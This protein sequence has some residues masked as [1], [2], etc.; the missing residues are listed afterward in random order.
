[1][2]RA[3]LLDPAIGSLIVGCFAVLFASAAS[4]KLRHLE[5]FSQIF[6]DYGLPPAF[7][8]WRVAWLVPLLEIAIAAGL[9][10][11]VSRAAAAALG[12]GLLLSYAFAIALNL[13]A[14][15]DAI[16]CGCGGL[17]DRRPI[18]AWM[19]WRNLLLA[20][21][22]ALAMLPWNARALEWTDGVTLGFGLAALTLLYFCAERLL[23][24]L[25][26]APAAGNRGTP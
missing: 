8:R 5:K 23:G 11:P 6:A 13:R 14:G 2:S 25:G 1:M 4:H 26:R 20:I 9:L 12:A 18:A 16:A 17:D 19:V 3:V 22:L 24:E 7:N 15:R 21:V 10:P